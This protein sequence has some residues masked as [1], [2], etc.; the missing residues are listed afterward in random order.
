MMKQYVIINNKLK[1]RKGKLS[2]ICLSLGFK[3]QEIITLR[4]ELAW[5]DNNYTAVILKADDFENVIKDL[6]EKNIEFEQHVDAGLTS[7]PEGSD[8]GLVFFSKEE[9]F[10]ELKLL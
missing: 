4:Q 3:S 6:I 9:M 5:E 8:C 2:R 10:K 1:M 7:V